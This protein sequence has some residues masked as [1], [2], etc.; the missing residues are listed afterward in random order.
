MRGRTV[1]GRM[2]SKRYLKVGIK[3][4][5]IKQNKQSRRRGIEE[6]KEGGMLTR[7]PQNDS[8][9]FFSGSYQPSASQTQNMLLSWLCCCLV[10]SLS[11]K[12]NF[13]NPFR[14]DI[15][16]YDWFK[17]NSWFGL[18]NQIFFVYCLNHQGNIITFRPSW[19]FQR[20]LPVLI[21]NTCI[22]S[23]SACRWR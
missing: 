9:L 5:G 10:C 22:M 16:S 4:G 23:H 1:N 18:N 3:G 19:N 15:S 17:C 2:W 12:K 14:C 21:C 20:F 13:W 6:V 7:C 11:Q 8:A